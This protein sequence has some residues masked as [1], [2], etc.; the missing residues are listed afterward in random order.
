MTFISIE[1]VN[2]AYTH[3]LIALE[4]TIKSTIEPYIETDLFAYNT[5]TAIALQYTL[6]VF[7]GII[8]DIGTSHKSIASYS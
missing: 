1:L 3:L 6:M 7:M 8:I 2:K 5:A 4:F